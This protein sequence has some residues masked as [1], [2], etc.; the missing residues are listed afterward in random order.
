MNFKANQGKLALEC[1]YSPKFRK[2]PDFSTDCET[3]KRVLNLGE[4]Y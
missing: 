3:H 4:L 1:F 2:P